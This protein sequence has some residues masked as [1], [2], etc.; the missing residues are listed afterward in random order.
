MSRTQENLMRAFTGE[1]IA[2]NKYTFYAQKAR[3]EGYEFV[4]R[5]FEET[6]DNERAHAERLYQFIKGW[7]ETMNAYN[8]HE[9][10]TTLENLQAAA[11][12]EKYEWS[13][14]YPEFEK[15]AHED[16][17][18]DIADVFK[19]ISEVEEQHEG[20]YVAL[21]AHIKNNTL[22]KSDKETEWKCENCG[23]VHHGTEAPEKCPACG[24]PRGW[25][26]RRA[27]NY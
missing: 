5:I 3:A 1:S 24:K 7:V 2:R 25:Y 9:N 22:Y 12:G 8:I 21:A 11:E 27:R 26:G 14:M 23:Y 6:S 13:S 20:R 4:A 17:D 15:Q 10:A 16:G 19:E 18:N